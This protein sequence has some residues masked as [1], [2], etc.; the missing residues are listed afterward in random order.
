MKILAIEKPVEGIDWNSASEILKQEAAHVY[1][2]QMQSVL[3]EV[4]FNQDQCAVLILECKDK[5]EA[6]S[7]LSEFP[8]VKKNYIRFEI[9]E[10]LPYTGFERLFSDKIN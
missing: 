6:A 9:H 5:T 7:I 4:Y 8:L 1:M 10:L 3:R 2:L